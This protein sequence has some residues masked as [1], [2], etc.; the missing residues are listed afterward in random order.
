[1]KRTP[2]TRPPPVCGRNAVRLEHGPQRLR[3]RPGGG[4]A[5]EQPPEA[6]RGEGCGSAR[7]RRHKTSAAAAGGRARS[8]SPTQRRAAEAGHREVDGREQDGQDDEVSCRGEARATGPGPPLRRRAAGEA[9]AV[10]RRWP[11]PR[12][13]RAAAGGARTGS[14]AASRPGGPPA[15]RAA[16]S[17][18]GPAPPSLRRPSAGCSA[19]ARCR[20][21]SGRT[22]TAPTSDG[23]GR[24]LARTLAAEAAPHAHRGRAP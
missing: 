9:A 5:G 11:L 17:C 15:T 4:A 20:W 7:P 23:G 19:R 2:S 18:A 14:P 13:G 21:R 16:R 1:M 24:R 10:P 3:R 12:P 22:P 6:P 8:A